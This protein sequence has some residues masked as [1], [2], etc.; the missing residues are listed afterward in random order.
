[1]ATVDVKVLLAVLL[2]DSELVAITKFGG[3]VLSSVGR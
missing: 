2:D 1:M 3:I